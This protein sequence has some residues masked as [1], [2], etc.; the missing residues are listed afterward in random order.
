MPV[1]VYAEPTGELPQN[2]ADGLSLWT[3][4][5]RCGE[6]S[7]RVVTDSGAA[8]IIVRNPP[9]L[10][11]PT[12][13]AAV[14]AADSVGACNGVTTGDTVRVSGRL[15]I[16]GPIRS[17]VSPLSSDSTALAG[18]YRIV[19]AHE[20]GHALGLLAHSPDTADLM[21]NRP[22]RRFLT[23]RDRLTIQVLYH[24]V[25]TVAPPPR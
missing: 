9:D 22:R 6:V 17:Y 13:R 14:L 11:E 1:R 24:T 15:R 7:S 5:F 16:D 12:D 10:P 3:G 25:P 2:V 4:A 20:L 23:P 18:C 8:D 21:N 19:T